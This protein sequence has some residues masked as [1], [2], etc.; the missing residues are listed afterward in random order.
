[1]SQKLN[2]HIHFRVT[3]EMK[4]AFEAKAREYNIDTN[5]LGRVA[6]ALIIDL[7]IGY[8]LAIEEAISLLRKNGGTNDRTY[9]E[10]GPS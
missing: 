4:E 3:R 5:T 7:D 9:T 10:P 2:A 1:M 6:V 8:H